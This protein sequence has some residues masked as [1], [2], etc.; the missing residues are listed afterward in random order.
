MLPD[1]PNLPTAA[2]TEAV[3][4][5]EPIALDEMDYTL[6][7]AVPG[8][9]Y[10]RELHCMVLNFP[11]ARAATVALA[12]KPA[13]AV[14]HPELVE[15]RD[16]VIRDVKPVDYATPLQIHVDAPRVHQTLLD[17]GHDWLVFDR[18][19]NEPTTFSRH[20][21]QD[22]QYPYDFAPSVFSPGPPAQ[23]FEEVWPNQDTDL[24]Y[25]AAI[26]RRDHAFQLGW[27]RG[28]G[29]TLGTA[30]LIE[31]ND[32]K[33]VLVAAPNNAK[34][35]TWVRELEKRLH[36]YTILVMG[37]KGPAHRDA[38]LANAKGLHDA[39]EPFVLIIHHEAVALVAGKK[40]RKASSGKTI[41][42][43]WKKLKITWDLFAVDESHRLKSSGTRGSQFHRA[44]CKVPSENRLALTGSLYENSWEEMYGPVHFLLPDRY[45]SKWESWNNRFLDFVEGY[46][47]IFVGIL[48]GKEQ[49]LRE[50]LGVFTLVREKRDRSIHEKILVDLSRAQ[51]RAYDDMA[52][53]MLAH[54]PDDTFVF[55]EAGVVQMMRLRQIATG[56]DLLSNKVTDSSK[57]DAAMKRIRKFPDH[58]FFVATWHKAAAYSLAEQLEAR[59][60]PVFVVTGDIERKER[61][62]RIADARAQTAARHSAMHVDGLNLGQ[63]VI[64][65][66]TIATL[67]ES[68]NLQFLNH[69]IRLQLS[70]NPALNRQVVDRVD[71]TGQTREVLCDDIIARNTIEE[72][73]QLPR[74]ANKDAF[75][76]LLF[77]RGA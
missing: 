21:P 24:G 48:P 12:L 10:S 65:I 41:L 77:G 76:A 15:L 6:A 72:T 14:T 44:S 71:R 61:D 25:A 68:I 5:I 64:V 56:L 19:V 23:W 50:E 7:K 45:H 46:G 22:G 58:D 20:A 35:D 4:D 42:D 26:L 47:K 62:A 17:D 63:P 69:V 3:L 74:L 11:T 31:A 67:G 8:A 28:G 49:A 13:L 75:R 40:D 39:G 16:S 66:G 59:G 57:I 55:G 54:L 60:Y 73:E 2:P 29:K 37:N 1:L 30:A 43:G 32:Y 38:V 51:R 52:N 53:T 36:W 27:T 9:T 33:S 34:F 18:E 70:D